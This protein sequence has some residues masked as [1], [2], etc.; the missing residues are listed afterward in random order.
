MHG[1]DRVILIVGHHVDAVEVC[2]REVAKVELF[3]DARWSRSNHTGFQSKV[4]FDMLYGLEDILMLELFGA[5]R[6]FVRALHVIEVVEWHN[7]LHVCGVLV[8]GVD[9][10]VELLR[11]SLFLAFFLGIGG[12]L[13]LILFFVVVVVDAVVV[14]AVPVLVPVEALVVDVDVSVSVDVAVVVMSF[15]SFT[16]LP[17]HGRGCS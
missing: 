4:F 8:H 10:A 16:V 7:V 9:V 5:L 14:L 2:I 15:V 17:L 3:G 11:P 13:C 12:I 6:V 1:T